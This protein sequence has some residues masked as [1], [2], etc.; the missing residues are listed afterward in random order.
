MSLTQGKRSLE[1]IITD[2]FKFRGADNFAT[3]DHF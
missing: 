2:D 1:D 3:W